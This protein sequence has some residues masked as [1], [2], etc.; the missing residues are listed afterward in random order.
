L[1]SHPHQDHFGLIDQLEPSIPIYIGELSQNLISASRKFLGKSLPHNNFIHFEKWQPFR[2]RDF[3]ITPYL[4]D[5]SA[6]DAYAF[7]IRVFT[8]LWFNV[9]NADYIPFYI[10]VIIDLKNSG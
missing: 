6:P 2:F 8:I 7:M 10:A 3:T 5:H 1:V 9:L 4:M